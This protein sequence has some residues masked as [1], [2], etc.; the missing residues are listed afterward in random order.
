MSERKVRRATAA[1][2]DA[3]LEIIRERM[4][5]MDEQGL[6]QWNCTEYLEVYPRSY[7]AAGVG[8]GDFYLMEED[9][10][11][12]GE[13]ALFTEDGRWDDDPDYFYLHHLAT[14]LGHPRA[15]AELLAYAEDLGRREGK[16]GIRLDSAVDNR[17]LN[18]YYEALG[19]PAVG[20]FV[21]GP[22]EGVNRVKYLDRPVAFRTAAAADLETLWTLEGLCF[23]PK[24]MCERANF[25][26]RLELCPDQFLLLTEG[27][28]GRI[29]GFISD[30]YA[31]EP[32]LTDEMFTGD[33]C[34]APE[35]KNLMVLGLNVH[36]DCRR[37]GYAAMLMRRRIAMAREAGL[38]RCVLTCHDHLIAYYESFGYVC[39][40][41]SQSV[42]GGETWYDMVLEL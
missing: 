24:E 28:E 4:A 21:E 27:A 18:E 15:G 13:M 32:L 42:W 2:V 19:Y 3:I 38:E 41:V 6:E 25:E 12:I 33:V 8:R 10:A 23:P 11:V 31:E 22:Y 1:D 16:K 35:G 26:R 37:R 30:V 5:W 14:R 7:F 29:C 39:Q 36:P 34:H 40:G 20:T 9:G 17:P